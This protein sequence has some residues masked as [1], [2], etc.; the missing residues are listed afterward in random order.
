VDG[1]H[2]VGADRS[3][4]QRTRAI[5]RDLPIRVRE[6]R[7]AENR[8]DVGQPTAGQEQIPRRRELR[9]PRLVL[10]RDSRN[11]ASTTKP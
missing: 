8:A 4:V 9:E 6:V 10:A 1:V 7:V 3:A 2:D 11:V 5:V